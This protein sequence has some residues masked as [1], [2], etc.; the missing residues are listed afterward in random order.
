MELEFLKVTFPRHNETCFTGDS[1]KPINYACYKNLLLH[2]EDIIQR[3][4]AVIGDPQ[5]LDHV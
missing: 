5:D 1:L 3:P 4:V 2:S